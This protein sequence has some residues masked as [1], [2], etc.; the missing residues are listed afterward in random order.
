[1]KLV[2]VTVGRVSR[3]PLADEAVARILA[4]AQCFRHR[5]R[6]PDIPLL[7]LLAAAA[8]HQGERSSGHGVIDPIALADI[9]PE[10]ADPVADA[11]PIAK[12]SA[13]QPSDPTP[14]RTAGGDIGET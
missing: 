13:P 10:L 7:G 14:R 11:A 2:L 4:L 5:L 8:Q 3:L 6:L 9:D 1:M 12:Q